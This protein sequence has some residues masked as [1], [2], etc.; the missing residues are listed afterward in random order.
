M[1]SPNDTPVDGV[2][3]IFLGSYDRGGDR[4]SSSLKIIGEDDVLCPVESPIVTL[5]LIH[6]K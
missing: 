1:L 3:V 6:K 5:V 4:P 2:R